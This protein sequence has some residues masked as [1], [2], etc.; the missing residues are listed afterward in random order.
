MER[1]T[2]RAPGAVACTSS[3]EQL[4]E[5]LGEQLGEQLPAFVARRQS[6]PVAEHH[7][8]EQEAGFCGLHSDW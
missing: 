7:H 5:Q 4:S 1:S 2:P 3:A 6:L 8:P